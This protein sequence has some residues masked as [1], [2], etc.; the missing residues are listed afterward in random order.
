VKKHADSLHTFRNKSREHSTLSSVINKAFS[1]AHWLQHTV[2]KTRFITLR[3]LQAVNQFDCLSNQYKHLNGFLHY[4]E[5][6]DP[7]NFSSLHSHW[8]TNC[9]GRNKFIPTSLNTTTIEQHCH[10]SYL[11]SSPFLWLSDSESIQA[12]TTFDSLSQINMISP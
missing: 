4:S 1:V 9:A 7:D 10:R 8:K 12:V 3:L 2:G 6:S 11:A 5:W